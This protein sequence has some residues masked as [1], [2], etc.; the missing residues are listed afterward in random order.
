MRWPERS[1]NT[2]CLARRST[3]V[4]V[5]PA[6]VAKRRAFD[7]RR[8]TSVLARSARRTRRPASSGARSRTI[9]STSG[10]SGTL[11]LPPRDVPTPGLAFE[12]DPLACRRAAPRGLRDRAGQA[13]HVEHAAAGGAEHSIGIAIGPRVEDQDIGPE[14]Q[15][16]VD[17]ASLLR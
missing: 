10:S 12:M 11:D 14:V 1:R 9:V 3:A 5:F 15:R 2:A 13:R 16:Q 4:M 17:R 7:T 8:N 6:S